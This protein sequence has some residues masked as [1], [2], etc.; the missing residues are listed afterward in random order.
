V[1][2]IAGAIGADIEGVDL[3][4]SLDDATIADIRQALLRHRVVFF[5]DQELDHAQHIAFAARFGELTY[6]HPFDEQPPEGY[7]EIYTVDFDRQLQQA[8][9]TAEERKAFR[10]SYG[11]F[12]GWHS[13]VTPAVNPPFASILRAD[14]VPAVGGDTTWTSLVAAYEGLSAP[15][16]TFVDGLWAEHRYGVGYGAASRGMQQRITAN[17]LVA[18]HPVVRVHPETGERALLVNPGFTSHIIGLS[19]DES[20]RILNLLF[21]EISRPEYTVRFRWTPGSVAFWD[22]RTSAHE[23][24][25]DLPDDEPRRLYRVTLVGDVPVGPDGR[26]S[27]LIEG[28]PFGQEWTVAAN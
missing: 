16:R 10:R 17:P 1:R 21:E 4:Q 28:V 13:D 8:G 15:L 12:G 26:E 25:R 14:V 22:N 11:Q 6:A 27:Q 18:H 3:S 9:V 5:R 2:P 20:R 23:A 24:P 7:R 19:A